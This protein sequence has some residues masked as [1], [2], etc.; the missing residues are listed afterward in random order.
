MGK[1]C[2]IIMRCVHA[3]VCLHCLRSIPR[4]VVLLLC[5]NAL[6]PCPT[7][8]LQP[9]SLT[10]VEPVLKHA[11]H[12]V[13]AVAAEI[14][15][16]IPVPAVGRMDVEQD[17]LHS[18]Q[19]IPDGV[20]SVVLSTGEVIYKFFEEDGAPGGGATPV[21]PAHQ[22]APTSTSDEAWGLS[23]GSGG[24]GSGSRAVVMSASVVVEA[25]P[26]AALSASA[27]EA[28]HAPLPLSAES[29]FQVTPEEALALVEELKEAVVAAEAALAAEQEQTTGVTLRVEYGTRF[30]Q[31][32]KVVG[33]CPELGAWNLDAAPG[34]WAA[35]K[36]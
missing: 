33:S 7:A 28:S 22:T 5:N 35:C 9:M 32:L 6:T 17:M 16:E 30:G 15:Q 20:Q 18:M 26:P 4:M 19:G 34:E 10:V 14:E 23:S 1:A 2:Q 27:H 12:D 21:V 31:S 3:F 29:K 13:A 36:A 25:E 24:R 8:Y 11:K